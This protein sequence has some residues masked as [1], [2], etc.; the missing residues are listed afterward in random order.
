MA[1]NKANQYTTK[2]A[3][4]DATKIVE[5]LR[6]IQNSRTMH[7]SAVREATHFALPR[8][9]DMRE[10]KTMN[11]AANSGGEL[12]A[13]AN[14]FTRA[15]RSSNQKMASGM[16]SYMTPKNQKWFKI[17]TGNRDLDE[18]LPVYKYFDEVRDVMLDLLAR[19][20]FTEI[21]HET[22]LNFGAIGTVCTMVE[23][24]KKNKGLILTDFPYSTFWFTE[25]EEGRPN[26]VYREF[27]LTPEQAVEKWGEENLENCSAVM[28]AYYSEDPTQRREQ[29]KFV[30]LVEPNKNQIVGNIDDS[31]KPFQSTYIS[32]EDSQIITKGGFK[33]LPY[34]V[35]RFL[36]YNT[37]GNVMG[38]S[39]T[40]DCMPV[41]KTLENLKKKFIFAV[42]KN[43]N[44]AMSRG[45]TIGMTPNRVK[46]TPNALNNFDSRN[47]ESKPTPILQQ[48]DLSYTLAELEAEVKQIE[49]AYY[50]PSF[51]TITNIDKSNATA[52]E[53]IARQQESL[54]SISPSVSRTEDE[55]LEPVLEDVFEIAAEQ[56]LLPEAPIELGDEALIRL[57]F[58]GF[59]SS[60][61]KLSESIAIMNYFQERTILMEAMPESVRL[62][63]ANKIKFS[64]VDRILA[65]NR[66]IPVDIFYT[67]SEMEERSKKDAAIQAEQQQQ[68][69]LLQ[70]ASRQDLNKAPEEGSVMSG[71]T[72]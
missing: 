10:I 65:E 69:E 48:I 12:A 15:A 42:E 13:Y 6:S 53:I 52:T 49:D 62:E 45:V 35:A 28:K 54:I 56:G 55:W 2:P 58:T 9:S 34:K 30:H 43:L 66:N 71:V 39:P 3:D 61:P 4:P 46:T 50:V 37:A 60:A 31:G 67:D 70:A 68:S 33:R 72:G 47:P 64:E 26:R 17:T 63:A 7:D 59:L 16:F 11:A 20:N 23:W 21:S 18:S 25:D 32:E 8:K 41:I 40:M 51:Q 29:M 24:S 36:K 19:S 44:P 57:E 22:Y 38:Y 5:G 27:T 14:L 1:E